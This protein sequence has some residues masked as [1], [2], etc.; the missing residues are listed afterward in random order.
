M[1]ARRVAGVIFIDP[2]LY[3]GLIAQSPVPCVA[4]M[5]QP[6]LPGLL[7]IQVDLEQII[8]RALDDLASKGRKRIGFLLS[9]MTQ[10]RQ[11][12]Y[13]LKA[14][15]A[16]GMETQEGWTIG[17]SL[18]RSRWASNA[19]QAMMMQPAER[20]PDGL[21][22]TDDHLVLPAVEGLSRVGVTPGLEIDVVGHSNHGWSPTPAGAVRQLG[23]V[24]RDLLL[25]AVE[26]INTANTT[27]KAPRMVRMKPLFAEEARLDDASPASLGMQSASANA[28]PY[29][30]ASRM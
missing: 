2:Y 14:V 30:N 24:A 15:A 16:R 20:R 29:A 11:V 19:V 17:L 27:G 10:E 9:E 28:L 18:A 13:L 21:V 22:I 12:K 8:D 6:G 25:Q 5:D 4:F 23:Y 1:E 3:A 7:S 26:L